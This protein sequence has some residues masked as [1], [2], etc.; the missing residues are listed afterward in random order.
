MCGN[1]GHPC[2]KVTHIFKNCR[3]YQCVSDIPSKS[4]TYM[5]YAKTQEKIY[6]L[7]FSRKMNIMSL[8]GAAALIPANTISY[9]FERKRV[10]L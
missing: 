4:R 8:S 5:L 6:S 9:F 2:P 10:E 1:G 3:F 7:A